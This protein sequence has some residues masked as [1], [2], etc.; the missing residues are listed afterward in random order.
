MYNSKKRLIKINKKGSDAYKI[1]IATSNTEFYGFKFGEPA[2]KLLTYVP[3]IYGA[4][5][6]PE[7]SILEDTISDYV[8]VTGGIKLINNGEQFDYIYAITYLFDDIDTN[9]GK[10]ITD[11]VKIGTQNQVYVGQI[12][13]SPILFLNGVYLEQD[14]YSYNQTDGVI[15]FSGD[16]ITEYMDMVVLSFHNIMKNNNSILE[17]QITNDNI[18]DNNIVVTHNAIRDLADFFNPIVF[19]SGISTSV[20]MQDQIKIEDDTITI[21]NFGPIEEGNSYSL[22]AVDAGEG[23]YMSSGHVSENA[24]IDENIKEDGSYILF[25]DGLCMSPR[26]F[27]ISN[28]KILI[29]GDL[30]PEGNPSEYYLINAGLN[31][32]IGTNVMFD[33]PVSYF[34]C[35]LNNKNNNVVYD[36]CNMV[37]SYVSNNETNI[38]GILIDENFIKVPL[39]T[40]NAY[41]TG[42]ILNIKTENLLGDPVY[43]YYI[44]NINGDYTWTKFEDEYG[45]ENLYKLQD[46]ITQFNGKGSLSIMSNTALEGSTLTYYA[47]TYVDEID[48][49][50][51][52]GKRN[53][54]INVDNHIIEDKQDF[55]TNKTQTFYANKGCISA[56]IN[57]VQSLDIKDYP[58]TQCKFTIDT[59]L[60]HDFINWKNRD[61]YN[62]IKNIDGY[63]TVDDLELLSLSEYAFDEKSLEYIKI[64]SKCI[65]TM[66]TTND[67]YYI[68][69]RTEGNETYACNRVIT[70]PE[71]RYDN[72]DNTY[73]SSSYIGPGAINVFLNGVLLEKAEYSIFDNC[74][75][76]LNEIQT[77]GGSDEFTRDDKNTWTL[78]KYY[79]DGELK[80]I[81][82][83]EPDRLLLELRPDTSIKKASYNI[84]EVSYETQAFDIIDY[85]YPTSLRNT[86]DKIK[87]YINGLLYTGKYS[88]INGVIT[89]EDAPLNI[90]PIKLYFDSHPDEYK[91]YKK[92]NGEYVASKDRI[93]FEWR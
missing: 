88:N 5:D 50:L 45:V 26:E 41:I 18:I 17:L 28:K 25:I 64:L 47:Y 46:M 40:E 22:L 44:Y 12:N 73:T 1:N 29:N 48:E 6:L 39:D 37:I 35:R 61:M 43:D 85:D 8:P 49:A 93:T 89:L 52:D 14:Y 82:C 87:I 81:Y 30:N 65:N 36:D 67:L 60:S 80:K 55:F 91:E 23:A 63:T 15:T 21:Y 90:D 68:V 27:E 58:G 69:E 20:K 33:A 32:N 72:F 75:I 24:I 13:D 10:M 4:V 62:I 34:T 79:T 53:C 51:L 74:N 57:G 56:Y 3:K 19:I 7:A 76:I 78:I 9:P 59:P 70:G 71:N 83:K 42:Q 2:G 16:T 38:N 77:A 66:E 54:T 84:K 31:D 86:K 92:F 11:T